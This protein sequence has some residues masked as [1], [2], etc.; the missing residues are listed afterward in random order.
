MKSLCA[1]AVALVAFIGLAAAQS[2]TAVV[3]DVQGQV[4]GVEFLDYVAPGAIIKIGPDGKVVLGYMKS[5]RRETITGTGTVVV[6]AAESMAQLSTIA[7]SNVQCDSSHSQ[8]LDRQVRESAASVVRSLSED[9]SPQVTLYGLSPVV[10]ATARGKLVVERLDVPGE[11]YDVNFT[12][13]SLTRGKFYDFAR[14][15]T[16]LQPGG[17]YAASLGAQRVVFRV[18]PV[19]VPGPTPIIG[20]LV[21]LD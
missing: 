14:S 17:T 7:A 15:G 18:D 1:A 8:L 5:C 11:R 19:A 16:A 9:G 10:E 12:A 6:G 3:E 21:S 13:P 2:P 4:T 20:R